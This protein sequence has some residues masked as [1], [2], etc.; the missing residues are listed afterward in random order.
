MLAQG[1]PAKVIQERLGHSHISIT[2]TVY[3]HA[4]RRCTPMRPRSSPPRS[5]PITRD[6]LNIVRTRGDQTLHSA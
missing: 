1:V 5:T 6:L 4:T 2:L 3:A